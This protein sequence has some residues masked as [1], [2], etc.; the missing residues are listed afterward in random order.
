MTSFLYR[1]GRAAVRRRRFVVVA[2]LLIAIATIGGQRH[3]RRRDHRQVRSPRRGGAES[4][5]RARGALSVGRGD[6]GP[7]GVRR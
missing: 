1:L 3:N 7:T 6:V 4:T 2:W 5:R